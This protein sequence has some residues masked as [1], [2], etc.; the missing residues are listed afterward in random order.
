MPAMRYDANSALDR[1]V[2]RFSDKI[3]RR[4]GRGRA[5]GGLGGKNGIVLQKIATGDA[6]FMTEEGD[7]NIRPARLNWQQR[8]FFF[9]VGMD[10]IE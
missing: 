7:G 1:H 2:V 9:A 4:W 6:E 3:C 8:N 5:R 10:G